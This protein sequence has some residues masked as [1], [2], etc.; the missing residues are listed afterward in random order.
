MSG[1]AELALL[2]GAAQVISLGISVC[3]GII[4]Y[5]FAFRD[6]EETIRQ[7]LDGVTQLTKTLVLILSRLQ[8]TTTADIMLDA[9][10]RVEQSVLACSNVVERMQKKLDKLTST[11]DPSWSTRLANVRRKSLYPF[12]ESTIIKI[13]EL[14]NDCIEQLQLAIEVLHIDVG[15][16]TLSRLEGLNLQVAEVANGVRD[17]KGDITET[18]DG[19]STL[20]LHNADET[21]RRAIDWLSPLQGVFER[22]QQE[23]YNLKG[24]Q[25]RSG[26]NLLQNPV[27]K[28]WL[29]QPGKVLWCVG[30]PGIGKTVTAS[31]VINHVQ[32][33]TDQKDIGIAYV[34]CSYKETEREN[35]KN[36]TSS[37]L[38]QL[39]S[40][41]STD[42]F[43]ILD[44]HQKHSKSSTRPTLREFSDVLQIAVHRFSRTYVVVDALDECTDIDDNRE[45]FVSELVSL[46]PGVSLFIVSRP[47]P[48][49]EQRLEMASRIELKASDEDIMAYVRERMTISQRLKVH[50]QKDPGLLQTIVTKIT[51]KVKGMFL[52]ARLYLDSILTMI[53]PRKVKAALEL[54]PEGL[55]QVYGELLDRIEGQSPEDAALALRAL[56][57][58][59]HAV[60][61]LTVAEI[62]C[63]LAIE[64][65]DAELDKDGEPDRDLL[66]SVC[67]GMVVIDNET[68]TISL[69][70]YTAQ[71]YFQNSAGRLLDAG[72]LDL[73]QT[74]VTYLLFDVFAGGPC[75]SDRHLEDM[76][77][78]HPLLLYAAQNWGTHARRCAPSGSSEVGKIIT[79]LLLQERR[80]DMISQIREIPEF[81]LRN[82][83]QTFTRNLG[84]LS[85]ASSSGLEN[86]VTTLLDRSEGVDI[87]A[88]DSNGRTAIHHAVSH[89]GFCSQE[90][91]ASADSLPTSGSWSGRRDSIIDITTTLLAAGA[92]P[93]KPDNFGQTP[94]HCAA[95]H[96]QVAVIQKLL[97]P[98]ADASLAALDGYKGT[99]LY[100]AVEAGQSDAVQVLLDLGS[101]ASLLNSY[102]QTVFHRAAEE[103]HLHVTQILVDY[104]RKSRGGEELRRL[105]NIKD[106][107]GWTAMYRAA[108]LGHTDVAKLLSA[109]GRSQKL[110]K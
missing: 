49:L 78:S 23:H 83:S 108:D 60:R 43:E 30:M 29:T 35:V 89:L 77:R 10:Q 41:N 9:R 64:A 22:R 85:L 72:H 110:P 32:H 73:T 55:N 68:D 20:V 28:E 24:R 39:L 58:I 27:F 48:H 103:G 109:A 45:T 98:G 36:L 3:N 6:S 37:I 31:F 13:K 11:S 100:R 102:G 46:L 21:L 106:W 96:N 5:Y 50:L 33:I 34:Y 19:I 53:T 70:H 93:T 107:Y 95:A 94:L 16:L 62:Q 4:K 97:A 52:M 67:A 47:L 59:F 56:Y 18:K 1:V 88:Q 92:S 75:R 71:E 80:V 54:L 8:D 40:Q 79:T 69:V 74:C 101:D 82:Y 38:Q 76:L 86:A 26:Q 25:D 63:A 57:W 42:A 65:E 2:S 15:L 84:G 44:M 17:I 105:V 61:P 66:V 51:S 81:K 7:M 91:S 87:D 99:P 14:C 104:I 12:K 90:R